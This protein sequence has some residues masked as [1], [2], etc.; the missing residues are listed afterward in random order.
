MDDDTI[1]FD[2]VGCARCDGDGHPNLTFTRLQRPVAFET[3]RLTHWATCPVTLEPI[4]LM[5]AE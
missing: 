4:L 3:T 2:Q 1:T 5:V